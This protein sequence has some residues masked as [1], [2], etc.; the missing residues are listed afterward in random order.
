[1]REIGFEDEFDAIISVSTSF[2][3]FAD[4]SDNAKTIHSARAAL[5]K[6]G[7]LLLDLEN[8]YYLSHMRRLYGMAPTYLP[9]NRF[10]GW[11]EEATFFD[12]VS[13]SVKM[14]LRLW[15][16]G[17]VVKEVICRYRVYSLPEIR[18]VFESCCFHIRSIYGDFRLRPYD[19][20]SPRM[21][22]V[23]ESSK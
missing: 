14:R 6:D 1:M 12:P 9:V 7:E 3:Y 19:I 16:N 11:L 2:G 5:K 4:D 10:R 21:I 17:I 13:H 8:V 18:G 20:D 22:I 15:R 23:C